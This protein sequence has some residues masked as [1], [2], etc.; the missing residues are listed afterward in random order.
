VPSPLLNLVLLVLSGRNAFTPLTPGQI[1]HHLTPTIKYLVNYAN[2]NPS[3]L[4]SL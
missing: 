4:E 1:T 2:N 3:R